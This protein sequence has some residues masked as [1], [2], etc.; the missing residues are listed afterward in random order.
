LR[1]VE[2]ADFDAMRGL[3]S[4]FVSSEDGERK[5]ASAVRAALAQVIRAW[6]G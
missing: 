1:D 2:L 6:I 4:F 3:D 5:W